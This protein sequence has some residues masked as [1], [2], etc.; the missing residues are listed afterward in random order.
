[1]LEYDPLDAP[2]NQ[3]NMLKGTM[4]VIKHKGKD[5]ATELEIEESN[6]LCGHQAYKKHINSIAIFVGINNRVKVACG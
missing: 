3:T 1:V 5:Q 4:A 2:T 6:I